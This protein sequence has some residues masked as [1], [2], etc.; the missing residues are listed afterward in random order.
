MVDVVEN[1]AEVMLGVEN[2][3]SR[4]SLLP[5]GG[6]LLIVMRAS[7]YVPLL[8]LIIG[9]TYSFRGVSDDSWSRPRKMG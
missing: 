4:K 1:V 8:L 9:A 6:S 3:T 2:A 5:V 7:T